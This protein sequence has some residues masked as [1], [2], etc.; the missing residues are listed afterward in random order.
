MFGPPAAELAGFAQARVDA[1]GGGAFSVRVAPGVRT[2]VWGDPTKVS[3]G[4]I[5]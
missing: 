3:V 1:V 5:E 4:V 2:E